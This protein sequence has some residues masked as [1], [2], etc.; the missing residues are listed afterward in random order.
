MVI[1]RKRYPAKIKKSLPDDEERY[2]A[3]WYRDRLANLQLLEGPE[4]IAKKDQD[5]HAWAN[6]AFPGSAYE[7][8]LQLNALP[9]PLPS[10]IADFPQWCE[11]RYAILEQRLAE[12]LGVD[13]SQSKEEEDTEK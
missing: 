1:L 12:L 9:D 3:E 11:R 4:N 13:I 5:P 10:S 7:S 2:L 6:A 8:H